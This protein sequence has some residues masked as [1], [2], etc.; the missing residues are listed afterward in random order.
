MKNMR[1]ES[2]GKPSQGSSERCVKNNEGVSENKS[3]TTNTAKPRR[4]ELNDASL[5]EQQKRRTKREERKHHDT[6]YPIYTQTDVDDVEIEAAKSSGLCSCFV[7]LKKY[8]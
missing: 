2:V 3:Q 6:N 4:V 8:K 5:P 1:I 7:A